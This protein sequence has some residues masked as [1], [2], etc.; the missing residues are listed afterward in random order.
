[1]RGHIRKRGST[2]SIVVDIGRD[3]NGKRKQKWISGFK[4]KKEAEKALAEIIAKIEKNEFIEPSKITL[5]QFINEWLKIYGEPK[6]APKTLVSNKS[7]IDNYII[8]NLGH[9]ELQKLKPVEIQKFYNS[10]KE[11]QLSNTT[12][13][14]VHR[15]LN[16]ILKFAVKWQYIA[17]NP[18]ELVEA[19]KKDKKEFVTWNFEHVKKAKKIFKDTPIYIH[20]MIALYTGLRLGEICGLR[21]ED[22]DFKNQTITVRRTAQ[23]I[24]GRF[25]FKEPKTETSKGIISIPDF[26]V[27]ILKQEKNKQLQNKLIFGEKYVTEYEG[28]IS[29]WEDGRFKEPDYVTK[30]FRKILK[31]QS[32]I[33]V[34]RFHD[35]RHTHATL[36]LRSGVD[37]KIISKRLRH[38]RISTTADFYSHVDL[39][40]DREALRKLESNLS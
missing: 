18:C 30:K 29:I 37:L 20:V 40:M 17:K 32:D 22:I 13:N 38:G 16:Q 4:T 11:K 7:L 12:I 35:L 3:E 19:P 24:D 2:Y 23:R 14:Y 26:L 28:F 25:I 21:W 6:W 9:I 36:M 31:K 33:P 8:P 5:Q 27:Q 10:L 39:E 34:I 15:L 1:M